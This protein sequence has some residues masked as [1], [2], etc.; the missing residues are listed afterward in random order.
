MQTIQELI[1]SRT[2]FA[3][4]LIE[5]DV[6]FQV[7]NP[8]KNLPKDQISEYTPEAID[9]LITNKCNLTCPHCYRNSTAK[10]KIQKIPLERFYT[11][12]D[13]MEE[14]RVRFLKITGGEAFLV[15]ELYDIVNYASAKR[16]HVAI[17]SNAT[18]SLKN[19]WWDLLI[20]PNVFLGISLDGV[21]PE[22]NDI[23]RG[24]GSFN[25]TMH[26]LKIMSEQ[27]VRF[28]ITFTVNKHNQ[29]ELEEIVPLALQLKAKS[30][31]INFIEESGRALDNKTL[32]MD[33]ILNIPEVKKKIKILQEKYLLKIEI[34][35]NHGLASTEEDIKKIRDKKDNIICSAAFSVLALDSSLTAY[36][37]IYG[38]GG[39][40]NTR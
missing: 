8:Y 14:L 17:L 1:H 36:P 25:K 38:I 30:L 37:C 21:T 35:D 27:G 33:E 29:H 12:V 3:D 16:L 2:D 4:L 26:N 7:S 13:E 28:T 31:N 39:K 20:R 19:K 6:P 9:L 32:Y 10:D 11:L 15:K 5:S 24:K 40:K 23:I 22:T 18:L 34:T